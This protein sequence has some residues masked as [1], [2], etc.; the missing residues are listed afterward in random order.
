MARTIAEYLRA[1][2]KRTVFVICGTFHAWRHGIPERLAD[3]IDVPLKIVLPSGDKSVLRYDI[4]LE[5][6]DYIWR[7]E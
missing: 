7:H 1:K 3:I 6:A 5:D 4:L 2:P